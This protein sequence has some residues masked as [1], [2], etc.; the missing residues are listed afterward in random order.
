MNEVAS[1][2]ILDFISAS[3][4]VVLNH[5]VMLYLATHCF[6]R[7]L[8]C[9]LI[10]RHS[11]FLIVI[12]VLSRKRKK[13]TLEPNESQLLRNFLSL[14]F[15]KSPVAFCPAYDRVFSFYLFHVI[16]DVPVQTQWYAISHLPEISLPL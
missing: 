7:G 10:F 4:R 2:S 11:R 12:C 3:T 8:H 13:R 14:Y 15:P 5:R 9:S 16:L 6:A 1:A